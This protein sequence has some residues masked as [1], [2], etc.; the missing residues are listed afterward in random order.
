M[1]APRGV[2]KL[3]R[4]HGPMTQDFIERIGEHLTRRFPSA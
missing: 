4:R 3:A 1:D 2:A